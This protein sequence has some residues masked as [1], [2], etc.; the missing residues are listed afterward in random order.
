MSQSFEEKIGKRLREYRPAPP[1]DAKSK[2]LGQIPSKPG[3]RTN[4]W[5]ITGIILI[6]V[7]LL[8]MFPKLG[9][10]DPLHASGA[11]RISETT[12]VPNSSLVPSP[13]VTQ[14]P[15]TTVKEGRNELVADSSTDQANSLNL[16]TVEE[17]VNTALTND[18][19]ALVQSPADE[20]IAHAQVALVD[21][22][23]DEADHPTRTEDESGATFETGEAL[24]RNAEFEML[25][26]L[27]GEEHDKAPVMGLILLSSDSVDFD[28]SFYIKPQKRY[29]FKAYAD[30][31]LFFLYRNAQPNTEDD[32]IIDDF[33]GTNRISVSRLGYFAEIGV[34]RQ[35]SEWLRLNAGL[36][37]SVF[38]QNY[39]FTIRNF[40][41][42]SVRVLSSETATLQPIFD[43]PTIEIDHQLYLVGAKLISNFYIFPSM[44]NSL[45]AGVEYQY[46]LN[47]NQEFEF[48]GE[49]FGI[50][51][52]NQL[53]VSF[54]LR[55]L[56][57]EGRR[58]NFYVVPNIRYS[59]NREFKEE[60]EVISVK[61]FSVGITFSYL[62]GESAF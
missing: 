48:D 47:A 12:Q 2:I 57:F 11:P 28:P 53:L 59:F 52:P 44:G 58:G 41:P 5:Q 13:T 60:D 26:G 1:P 62:F 45:Y 23:Q 14:T 27:R 37:F 42:D 9:D 36:N 38:R 49:T 20:P 35:I 10:S 24:A 17:Q 43:E 21:E 46:S 51:Y 30:A 32:L 54:G 25:A 29:Q 56:L 19:D 8:Q 7:A 15:P 40:Q 61:P 16:T 34:H 18:S 22:T 3:K 6:I 39:S 33:Q 55:K 50:S 31:G 4:G